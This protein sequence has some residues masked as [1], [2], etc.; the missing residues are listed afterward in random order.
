MHLFEV[1]QLFFYLA[2]SKV[3]LCCCF[4]LMPLRKRW[5]NVELLHCNICISFPSFYSE[6]IEEA[7]KDSRGKGICPTTLLHSG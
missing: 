4:S 2:Y 1:F 7:E 6:R 3:K 5:N